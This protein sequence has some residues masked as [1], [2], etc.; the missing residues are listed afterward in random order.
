MKKTKSWIKWISLASVAAFGTIIPT[1]AISTSIDSPSSLSP[2]LTSYPTDNGIDTTE[3]N[4]ESV[5]IKTESNKLNF[6]DQQQI[7]FTSEIKWTGD[8]VPTDIVY[9][10]FYLTDNISDSV[11]L[12]YD[13]P[14]ITV[15]ASKEYN[16]KKFWL[17]ILYDENKCSRSSNELPITVNQIYHQTSSELTYDDIAFIITFSTFLAITL[18]SYIIVD[19]YMMYA[20][21]GYRY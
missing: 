20:R 10:W 6:D 4:A 8:L 5:T 11:L 13:Q 3:F 19:I 2:T 18:V 15:K 1:V 9:R 17:K 16:N 21:H 12:D 7:T 14:T